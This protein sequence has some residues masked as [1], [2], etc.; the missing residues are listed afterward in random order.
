MSDVYFVYIYIHSIN[1]VIYVSLYPASCWDPFAAGILT[2]KE[3]ERL[4][5]APVQTLFC[6]DRMRQAALRA[7]RSNQRDSGPVAAQMLM[8]MEGHIA[9]LTGAMGAMDG[10]TL[11]AVF[12][13]VELAY[14]APRGMSFTGICI[15]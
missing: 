11:Q 6:C 8:S 9:V 15:L 1:N 12:E 5:R 4:A 13:R 3:L 7:T 14:R 2:E 10:S